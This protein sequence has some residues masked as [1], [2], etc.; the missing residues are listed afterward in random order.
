MCSSSCDCEGIAV[1]DLPDPAPETSSVCKTCGEQAHL[2]LRKHDPYCKTCFLSNCTHKFRA[3]LGKSRLMKFGENVL[4][5]FSGGPS[6]AAMLRFVLEG[7]S[8]EAHKR[9]IFKPSL[10]YIDDS[11]VL[12]DD[13]MAEVTSLMQESGLPYYTAP[14]ERVYDT[15]PLCLNSNSSDKLRETFNVAYSGLRT[16]T[17]RES[18]YKLTL[19]N[20]MIRL[21]RDNGF[22]KVFTGETGTVLAAKLLSTIALGR[23]SQIRE[24]SGFV[25]GRDPAVTILRPMREFTSKEVALFNHHSGVRHRVQ[26]TPSTGRD[27]RASISRLTESFLN[28]LQEDFPSTISTVWRTGDKLVSRTSSTTL[29]K[30]CGSKLDCVDAPASSAVS[31]LNLTRQLSRLSLSSDDESGVLEGGYDTLCY[32]CCNLSKK[33]DPEHLPPNVSST[34]EAE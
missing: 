22:S 5:A 13:G 29:C 23:G 21:A 10:L 17:D 31:A 30:L 15:G 11:V 34:S 18:F 32:A 25:D 16:L 2:V 28:G 20:L 6:S 26:R 14:I 8:E 9:F 12:G 1:P 27:S 24:E 33:V 4:V 3:T 19:R 7:L